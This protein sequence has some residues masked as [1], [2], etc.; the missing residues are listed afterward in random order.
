MLV[1]SS[2]RKD[3][4]RSFGAAFVVLATIVMTML[5]I[6]TLS[7][8][9]KGSVNPSEVLM[10]MGFTVLGHLPTILTLSL[11]VAM[12]STLSRWYADSEMIIW[13][14]SGM[15]LIG[16]LRPLYRF[17]WPV[18]LA[19]A[20]LALF[21][22]P[23]TNQQTQELKDRYERRGD[24]ERIAPGEFQESAGGKRVFFIDKDTASNTVG[25]RVFI[26]M[27]QGHQ[28]SVISAA[29]GE[30]AWR[31][32]QQW[33]TLF[34]GQRLDR[35]TDHTDLRL[36]AFETYA[37]SVAS[38]P[39]N[40]DDTLPAKA[41]TITELL[42]NPTP[43]NRGELSWRIGLGLAAVNFVL[44][45]LAVARVNP[46]MG[47]SGNL[48]LA[49]FAFVIYFNFINM[50]QN[51]VALSRYGMLPSMVLLHGAMAALPLLWL[52]VRD[53]TWSLRRVLRRQ[54]FGKSNP[55]GP[56]VKAST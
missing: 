21:V 49:M 5:L 28:D 29:R 8:A 15:S 55:S 36:S 13:Q 22:W 50:V 27:N 12:V 54:F 30:L 41:R 39:L 33:L 47:R 18:L 20:L 56:E 2:L 19:I 51:W 46:R 24:L 11:F 26:A 52:S 17:A 16:F 45:A 42:A 31:D 23:W 43:I 48:L 34:N 35:A 6:R 38:N 9:A 3:L 53:R 10:V 25:K 37:V 14:S 1:H 32:G 40:D 7:Q 4:A 44:I